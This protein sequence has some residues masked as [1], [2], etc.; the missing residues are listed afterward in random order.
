MLR[1]V[2]VNRL[3]RTPMRKLVNLMSKNK[4]RRHKIK[5]LIRQLVPRSSSLHNLLSTRYR[6]DVSHKQTNVNVWQFR[7][8]CRARCKCL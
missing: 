3:D 2:I 6:K 8:P 1:G 7:N 5:K 4:K